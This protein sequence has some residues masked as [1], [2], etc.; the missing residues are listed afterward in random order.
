MD[1]VGAKLPERHIRNL[2]ARI[3]RMLR[4]VFSEETEAYIEDLEQK[5]DEL[6]KYKSVETAGGIS[7][8]LERYE[9]I[10]AHL[11][12]RL[13]E[14]GEVKVSVSQVQELTDR[15]FIDFDR[16]DNTIIMTVRETL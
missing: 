3:S 8:E 9:A 2:R 6:K 10:I 14:D 11:I 13:N 7:Q 12:Y 4:E 15:S 5:A 1:E 16:D